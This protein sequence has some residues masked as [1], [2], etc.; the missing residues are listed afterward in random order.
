MFLNIILCTQ[1]KTI[2]ILF[3]PER[4]TRDFNAISWIQEEC[5]DLIRFTAAITATF[6]L[7]TG[8]IVSGQIT[9]ASQIIMQTECTADR[10]QT[11]T[12]QILQLQILFGFRR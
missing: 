6:V 1:T 7:P 5:W 4:R 3:T 8:E 12:F 2:T 10:L 9:P 11:G